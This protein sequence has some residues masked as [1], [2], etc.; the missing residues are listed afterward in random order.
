M[1]INVKTIWYNLLFTAA[2]CALIYLVAFVIN[3]INPEMLVT[4]SKLFLALY[5]FGVTTYDDLL[6]YSLRI[7]QSEYDCGY[8]SCFFNYLTFTVVVILGIGLAFVFAFLFFVIFMLSPPIYDRYW[9]L[10]SPGL[11]VMINCLIAL[12]FTTASLF[13]ISQ[14]LQTML[15]HWFHFHNWSVSPYWVYALSAVV[16]ICWLVLVQFSEYRMDGVKKQLQKQAPDLQEKIKA[17]QRHFMVPWL[18]LLLIIGGLGAFAYIDKALITSTYFTGT[19]YVIALMW[20]LAAIFVTAMAIYF[21]TSLIGDSNFNSLEY[22]ITITRSVTRH[23]SYVT[24]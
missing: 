6:P 15:M 3:T 7:F 13:V 20:A 1:P 12:T 17:T 10:M 5:G 18:H 19:F 21:R 11:D 9:Y 22:E 24:E 14:L 23:H 8:A 16:F 2:F 4:L